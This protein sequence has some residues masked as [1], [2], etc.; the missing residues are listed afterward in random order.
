MNSDCNTSNMSDTS[1]NDMSD[2]ESNAASNTSDTIE[3]DD[4]I[5]ALILQF[6]SIQKIHEDIIRRLTAIQDSIGYTVMYEGELCRLEDAIE[7]VYEKSCEQGVDN[8]TEM[9]M[10][11][12]E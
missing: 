7:S 6:E 10:K 1:D 12:F 5:D 3:I 4:D 8:V 11:L 9:L 2:I